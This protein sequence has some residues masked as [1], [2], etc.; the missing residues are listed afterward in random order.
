MKS[1]VVA[2]EE[3]AIEVIEQLKEFNCFDTLN[4]FAWNLLKDEFKHAFSAG[5][6]FAY[7]KIINSQKKVESE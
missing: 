7:D 2:R 1:R 4:D 5:G 6:D 3:Y